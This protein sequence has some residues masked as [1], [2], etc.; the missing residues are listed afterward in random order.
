[1]IAWHW[2]KYGMVH[3]M[4]RH[5]MRILQC[6]YI[7]SVILLWWLHNLVL[8]KTG[9][10]YFFLTFEKYLLKLEKNTHSDIVL[11]FFLLLL[12]CLLFFYFL[13]FDLLLPLLSFS[14]FVLP[15][16]LSL[17]P[18][19]LLSLLFSL[20]FLWS[21]RSTSSLFLSLSPSFLL[22]LS[23]SLCL[24]LW[25]FFFLSILFVPLELSF[26]LPFSIY[27]F[28]QSFLCL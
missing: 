5:N 20:P 4:W 2:F 16:L 7:I 28:F 10:L 8:D 24:Y 6:I 25:H 22:Y 14:L 17:S 1:M 23:C 15:L 11:W 21:L 18:S 3:T 27:F 12:F 19:F 13:I 26:S 9:I